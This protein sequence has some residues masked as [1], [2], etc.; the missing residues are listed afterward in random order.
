VRY[1]SRSATLAAA[2]AGGG[3]GSRVDAD[4]CLMDWRKQC[5]E[6]ATRRVCHACEQK[7]RAQ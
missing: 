2:A 5:P 7:Q 4:A 3:G 6:N 1:C